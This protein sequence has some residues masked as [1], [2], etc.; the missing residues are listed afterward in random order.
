MLINILVVIQQLASYFV[1]SLLN[2][3]D[4][5]FQLQE[6]VVHY[7]HLYCKWKVWQTTGWVCIAM[8]KVSSKREGFPRLYEVVSESSWIV[9]T[10][11]VKE[12]GRPRSYFGKPIASVCHVHRTVNA[13]CFYT[14]AF[15]L[16]VSFCLW[17]TAKSSNMS[18]SSYAWTSVNPLPKPLKCFVRLLKNIL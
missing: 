14:S 11:S 4:H 3:H 8:A 6:V 2:Q 18:A 15:R 16:C 7:N 9:V 17:W 1:G 13:H 10:A 12:E 5:I